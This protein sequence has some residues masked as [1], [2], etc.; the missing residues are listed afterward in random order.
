MDTRFEWADDSLLEV[1]SL[2]AGEVVAADS[3]FVSEGLSVA[4][5]KHF[6][7]FSG[8]VGG[9]PEGLWPA[10]TR[11]HSPF[12]GVVPSCGV[13][14]DRIWQRVFLYSPSL[15]TQDPDRSGLG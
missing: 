12:R 10:L 13:R 6:S 1:E 14:G 15:P 2:P 9:L 3:W 8:A 11:G 4:N 7:R 5:E